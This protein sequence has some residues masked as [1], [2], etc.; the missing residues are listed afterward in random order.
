MLNDVTSSSSTTFLE[1]STTTTDYFQ[2][3][4]ECIV[5]RKIFLNFVDFKTYS[6]VEPD[7][8]L[9]ILQALLIGKR[10]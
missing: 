5:T 4:Y 9:A 6:Q 8:N 2:L 3:I 7:V 10:K 1:E